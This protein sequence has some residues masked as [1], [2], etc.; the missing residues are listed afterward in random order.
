[1][2]PLWGTAENPREAGGTKGST[3]TNCVL[4]LSDSGFE[5]EARLQSAH[6]ALGPWEDL[7]EFGRLDAK[8][9]RGFG[10]WFSLC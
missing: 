6:D 7:V 5:P 1:M 9:E 10:S 8:W 4:R 3:R 2:L